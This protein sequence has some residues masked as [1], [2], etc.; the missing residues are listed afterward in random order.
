[1]VRQGSTQKKVDKIVDELL[2]KSLRQEQL[3]TLRGRML[4]A[5]RYNQAINH[6]LRFQNHLDSMIPAARDLYLR[7]RVPLVARGQA[8]KELAAL[9][10][11]GE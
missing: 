10:Q 11:Q 3:L 7:S 8:M 4:L 9:A 5:N 6:R 2:R 1:M